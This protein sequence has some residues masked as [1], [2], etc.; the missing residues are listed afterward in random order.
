MRH[1]LGGTRGM[2]N[3]WNG[4]LSEGFHRFSILFMLTPLKYSS[5]LFTCSQKCSLIIL[6]F[7]F[8]ANAFFQIYPTYETSDIFFCERIFSSKIISANINFKYFNLIF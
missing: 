4:S 2:M 6:N 7:I 1:E 5:Y 3:E 8:K